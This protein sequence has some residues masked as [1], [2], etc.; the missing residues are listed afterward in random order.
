MRFSALHGWDVSAQEAVTLQRELAG[1]VSR[2][3]AAVLVHLVA[4]VDV[5]VTRAGNAAAAV[6]VLRYPELDTVEI[7]VRRGAASFP[8]FPGLLSFRELPLVLEAFRGLKTR[9]DLI[10]V[11]GQGVAHPRRF[12]IAAHLGVYLDR[13]AIGCAKSRLCGAADMPGVLC[14]SRTELRDGDEVIGAVLRTKKGIKPLYVSI[15][16]KIDLET[17]LGWVM[18][19]VRGYR[20]PEPLRRAHLAAG[21]SLTG[22][23]I[24]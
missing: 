12:G 10:M 11:D 18:K 14:G 20:L 15:G 16:H 6:V 19:C 1:R 8:Y 3:N 2:H 5:S 24:I 17:A 7:A 4:G 21:G 22:R 23:A 9:P 13:P